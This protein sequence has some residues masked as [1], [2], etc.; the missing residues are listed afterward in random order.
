MKE[1]VVKSVLN[2]KKKRDP[3]F[4]D[5]FTLNPY[6]GCSFNCQYCYIRGSKYG[7]NMEDTLSVK[8]NGCE[9]LDR[10]LAFRVKKGQQGIIALASATDPYI[11]AESTYRMTEGFLRLILKH[12]FP[13]LMI[14]KSD[15]I[16]RDIALLQEID[17]QAIHA[18]DL[19]SKLRRGAVVSFSLSTLDSSIASTLEPGAPLPEDRLRIMQRCKE[20]GLM[21][22]V[23]CIPTLPFITD[24]EAQL[25]QLVCAAKDHGADFI[26]IGGLTLFGNEAN[27]SKVLYYKF[28]ER[29]FPSLIPAYKNLYRIFFSPPQRYLDELHLKAERICSKYQIRRS[30]LEVDN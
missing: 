16:L 7:E 17:R 18:P 5:D 15:C 1:I 21:V 13:V 19:A 2:K 10:Q 25:D 26:H 30:I 29:K 14:T 6:E 11:K 3:W 24:S 20:A 22:G 23:N 4:L 12:R 9:V 27:S 28:L 8:I